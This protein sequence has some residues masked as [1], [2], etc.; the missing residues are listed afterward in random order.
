M[1]GSIEKQ[2]AVGIAWFDNPPVNAISHEVRQGLMAAVDQPSVITRSKHSS[3]P[4]VAERLWPGPILPSLG[5]SPKP[6]GLPDVVMAMS[7]SP[8]S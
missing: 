5:S 4:V 6:P 8:Q 3:S 7:E 2:G 1:Q